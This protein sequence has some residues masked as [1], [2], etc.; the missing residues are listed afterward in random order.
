MTVK[1][2]ITL[3]GKLQGFHSVFPNILQDINQNIFVCF[4]RKCLRD[5]NIVRKS[6]PIFGRKY[7]GGFLLKTKSRQAHEAIRRKFKTSWEL[8]LAMFL[9]IIFFQAFT[10]TYHHFLHRINFLLMFSGED[11]SLCLQKPFTLREFEQKVHIKFG[12]DHCSKNP[13]PCLKQHIVTNSSSTF[14][15]GI[16]F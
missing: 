13:L 7:T 12:L 6:A 8:K 10:P 11:K 5:L 1:D 2:G 4:Q 16:F 15:E 3:A 9:N 14:R